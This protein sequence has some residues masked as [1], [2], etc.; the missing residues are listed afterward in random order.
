MLFSRIFL[1]SVSE[2]ALLP[3]TA[4][5]GGAMLIANLNNLCLGIGLLRLP[6]AITAHCHCGLV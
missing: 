6:Y 1:T 4:F 3:K 5:Q 2:D